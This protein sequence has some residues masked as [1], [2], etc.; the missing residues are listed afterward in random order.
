[1]SLQEQVDDARDLLRL[2]GI[3][4]FGSLSEGIVLLL[5]KERAKRTIT[6]VE[7]KGAHYQKMAQQ[8][9]QSFKELENN[10]DALLIYAMKFEVTKL[11]YLLLAREMG[12]S[13]PA[14]L[15]EAIEEGFKEYCDIM[16]EH[17]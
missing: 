5:N 11:G 13:P 1:M 2:E 6:G 10:A 12:V 7:V 17:R 9:H 4:G 8:I 14:T 16:K 3:K 15:L